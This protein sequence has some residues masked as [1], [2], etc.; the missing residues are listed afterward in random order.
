MIY[1]AELYASLSLDEQDAIQLTSI[2]QMFLEKGRG[3][4]EA[5]V[6]NGEWGEVD[7]KEDLLIYE[8]S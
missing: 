2:L 7:Q 1:I 3:N 8:R 6:Y 5:I 4:V